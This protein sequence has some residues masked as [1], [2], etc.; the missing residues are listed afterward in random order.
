MDNLFDGVDY[1]P[2]YH[3][4][5]TWSGHSGS[6]RAP[7][8]DGDDVTCFYETIKF[9][10]VG[11]VFNAEEQGL[12]AIHYHQIVTR[13]SDDLV[14]HNQTGYWMWDKDSDKIMY[15]IA[16]PRAVCLLA[17]G[18]Y[19]TAKNIS[20]DLKTNLSA[21][22]ESIVQSEFMNQKAKTENFEIKLELSKEELSYEQITYLDIY[23]KKFEHKDSNRLT[24]K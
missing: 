22:S 7:K 17:E 21:P 14:Y 13:K 9:S 10:P 1:G 19:K 23:G 4:I 5:G 6:D 12:V 24:K 20:F 8:P 11:K 15:S 16:I 2:L 3:L 18:V